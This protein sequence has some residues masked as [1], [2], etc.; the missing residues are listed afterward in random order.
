M[1]HRCGRVPD[2]RHGLLKSYGALPIE[3]EP[4]FAVQLSRPPIAGSA[5]HTSPSAPRPANDSSWAYIVMVSIVMANIVMAYIVMV[6]IV[7]ADT[8]MAYIIMAHTV[9][10]CIVMAY[11]TM[12][13]IAV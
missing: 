7:M 2:V 11:I 1:W 4:R 13:A 6:S 9:M 10:A 12:Q 5:A 8:V 3:S